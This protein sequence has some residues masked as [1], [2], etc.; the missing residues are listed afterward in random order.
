MPQ[1]PNRSHQQPYP[2]SGP[3]S[4]HH[5]DAP[6]VTSVQHE[7]ASPSKS[8]SETNTTASIEPATPI[9]A[10]PVAPQKVPE[11][12]TT[13]AEPPTEPFNPPVSS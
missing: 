4:S 5:S 1:T 11:A 8:A 6:S 13:E 9:Q 2:P 3:G 12:Q 7:A 10:A